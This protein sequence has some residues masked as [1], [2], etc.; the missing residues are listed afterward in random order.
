MIYEKRFR[1]TREQDKTRD[2]T[3]NTQMLII[4]NPKSLSKTKQLLAISDLS[5]KLCLSSRESKRLLMFTLNSQ[6]KDTLLSLGK[7]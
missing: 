4:K 5:T 3:S 1:V 2:N 6:V 7:V